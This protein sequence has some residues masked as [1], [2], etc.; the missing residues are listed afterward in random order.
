MDLKGVSTR[1]IFAGLDSLLGLAPVIQ[2]QE[3]L[4]SR[5]KMGIIVRFDF[6]A[7]TADLDQ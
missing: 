7:N 4:D 2:N 3:F 5:K 1:L 6:L